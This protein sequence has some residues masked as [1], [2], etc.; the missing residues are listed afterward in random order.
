LP[1]RHQ[2]FRDLAVAQTLP[3]AMSAVFR[4]DAVDVSSLPDV[5]G[6]YDLWLSYLLSR[7]GAAAWFVPQ[8]L[9]SWRIHSSQV[10]SS[11]DVKW[12]IGAVECWAT[13]A[14]D[15][16]FRQSGKRIRQQLSI[17]ALAA[18]RFA[19]SGEARV[20]SR[21]SSIQALRIAPTCWRAWAAV[22]WSLRPK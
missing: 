9:T 17:A 5:G 7:D 18:A 2:P 19:N 13:M 8:L 4:R 14:S 1:G 10:S 16:R 15:K 3:I 12:M 6:A 22:L 11:R 20:A 21:A